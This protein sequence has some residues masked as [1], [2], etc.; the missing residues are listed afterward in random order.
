MLQSGSGCCSVEAPEAPCCRE[1][2]ESPA[3]FPRSQLSVVVPSY[4]H[5]HHKMGH[6]HGSSSVTTSSRLV[7]RVA[8][9]VACLISHM[10][11]EVVYGGLAQYWGALGRLHSR[12]GPDGPEPIPRRSR[13]PRHKRAPMPL[14]VLQV[15]IDHTA[16]Q[17]NPPFGVHSQQPQHTI[18]LL[19]GWVP[20]A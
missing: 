1:G 20:R 19:V 11:L 15:S 8:T 3:S 17:A 2:E 13:R 5:P 9:Y 12:A 7:S 16:P 18:M 6:K 4:E 14:Q 10:V